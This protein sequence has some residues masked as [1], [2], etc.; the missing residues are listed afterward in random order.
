LRSRVGA[1]NARIDRRPLQLIERAGQM[2]RRVL[3][4]ILLVPIA[5]VLVA[6]A[7]ANRQ[8]VMV[9]FDPFDPADPAFAMTMPLYLVGFTI[10][11]A[12]VV[13]GGI[14]AWL[15]QGK[16]RRARIRLASENGMIR[17]ELEYLRRQAAKPNGRALAHPAGPAAKTP[18]AA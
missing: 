9:S 6:L 16:W 11:I 14:A 7:V 5:A 17:T 3:K 4:T 8:P 15:E 1:A 13:V 2:I 12:G 18:P 10:L